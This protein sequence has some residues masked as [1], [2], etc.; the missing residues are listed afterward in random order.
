MSH[1]LLDHGIHFE[2]WV[3]FFEDEGKQTIDID[4]VVVDFGI[5][6]DVIDHNFDEMV[7]CHAFQHYMNI[8][9]DVVL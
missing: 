1:W 8:I 7:E 3:W 4:F 5:I 2:L 6:S 9:V